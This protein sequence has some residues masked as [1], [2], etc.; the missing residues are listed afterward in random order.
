MNQIS[1]RLR[2]N[3]SFYFICKPEN[4]VQI[5]GRCKFCGAVAHL[6]ICTRCGAAVVCSLCNRVRVDRNHWTTII[7]STTERIS[8]GICRDCME[9]LHPKVAEKIFNESHQF[10]VSTITVI[11]KRMGR[12]LRERK[13][14]WTNEK[15]RMN[16]KA[17]SSAC[18]LN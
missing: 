18:E 15:R 2:G 3:E 12:T 13:E 1:E 10:Q 8:H 4:K 16:Q 7:M 5:L 9:K 6:G 11:T 14:E 17:Y